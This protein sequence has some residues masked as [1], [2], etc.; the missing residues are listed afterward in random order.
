M[1]QIILV[2]IAIVAFFKESI[3][4]TKNTEITRPKTFILGGYALIAALIMGSIPKLAFYLILS[5]FFILVL[6]LKKQKQIK[7]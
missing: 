5:F 4:V 1:I 2:V 7:I 6:I 3:S